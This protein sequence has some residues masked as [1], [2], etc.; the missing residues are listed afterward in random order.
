MYWYQIENLRKSMRRVRQALMSNPTV[1][2][3][4]TIAS[5]SQCQFPWS[6]PPCC[7]SRRSR[8][9][10]SICARL[11]LCCARLCSICLAC[12][13]VS[14]AMIQAMKTAR[15]KTA[16]VSM[17]GQAYLRGAAWVRASFRRCW[18]CIG[19]SVT[20]LLG[21]ISI[22]TLGNFTTSRTA[23]SEIMSRSKIR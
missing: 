15:Q 9:S 11:C 20:M 22:R 6:W 7:C 18:N 5:T 14:V 12:C 13:S 10:R 17:R 21:Q 8:S 19:R 2:T 3:H 23:P 1:C 16:T 4:F